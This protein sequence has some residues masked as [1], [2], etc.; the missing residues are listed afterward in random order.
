MFVIGNLPQLSMSA[1]RQKD[2]AY[3]TFCMSV[4]RWQFDKKRG[5]LHE[6]PWHVSSWSN[7]VM[8]SWSDTTVTR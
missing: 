3:L 6:H 5:F 7:K 2:L 1:V 8:C 4:Y